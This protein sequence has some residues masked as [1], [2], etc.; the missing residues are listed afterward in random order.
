MM[1]ERAL[2]IKCRPGGAD[3][4]S[5]CQYRYG[6]TPPAAAVSVS[7]RGAVANFWAPAINRADA[8]RLRRVVCPSRVPPPD[9]R[10]DQDERKRLRWRRLRINGADVD[11]QR[12]RS[13]P[14]SVLLPPNT[15][16]TDRSI[17]NKSPE[18]ACR[19]KTR[20]CQVAAT[21]NKNGM[22]RLPTPPQDSFF[23]NVRVPKRNAFGEKGNGIT[24]QN[25]SIA[26]RERLWG[27]R[28][29]LK[30]QLII[31][32]ETSNIPATESFL[33]GSILEQPGIVHFQGLAKAD[34][35]PEPVAL[36]DLS[37]PPSAWSRARTD[38]ARYH[39]EAEGRV[40]WGENHQKRCLPAV[41]L[42]PGPMGL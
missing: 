42:G 1:A 41:V 9:V 24:Y 30:A 14:G 37:A 36:A 26:R 23:D 18:S 11:H 8:G 38:E 6:G 17:A 39:G 29:R 5:V 33:A 12:P 28:R 22:P 3:G 35:G 21:R 7:E 19:L 32:N 16:A 34:L 2:R 4:D 10:L 31:I 20:A 13:R 40:V 25:D 27:R 15:P